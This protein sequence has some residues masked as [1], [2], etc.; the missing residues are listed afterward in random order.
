MKKYFNK[1]R[2]LLT[3]EEKKVRK[4]HL[5]LGLLSG[6][7]MG[8]SFPP[9]PLPYLAFFGLIPYLYVLEERDGL[10]EINRF[11]YFTFFFFNLITLYWVGSWTKDADS[12][13]LIAG[14]TLMFFNPLL[15]LIPSTLYYFA[16][17]RFGK[18][19]ALFALPVFWGFYEYIYSVTDFRFPW[20]MLGNSLTTFRVFIQIADIIGAYGISLLIVY[21]NIMIY[22]SW[23]EYLSRKNIHFGFAAG[24]L[25]FIIVPLVY[26]FIKSSADYGSENSVRF[27]LIQPNINPW[28][29]WEAG[30]LDDQLDLYLDL[31]KQAVDENAKV[32]A[33]PESALPVYLLNGRYSSQVKRI[34]EFLDSNNVYLVT[35]M[36][37][38]TFYF[39]STKAPDDAKRSR[40]GTLYTS[41]NSILYFAPNSRKVEKYGKI[42]LVPFGEKVPLVESIPV[43]GDL[44]KWNVGISSWNTGRGVKVF[45]MG[46]NGTV[47][48]GVICIESIYPAF[49]AEFVQSG[50]GVIAVVTNDSWYGNSSGPYQHKDIAVMRAIEN[51]R[52]VV[53]AANGGISCLIDPSGKIIKHT[54]M[55]TRD[56]LTVDVSINYDETFFS[57]YP[58]LIPYIS[59]AGTMLL[60][61]IT[62]F[63]KFKSRFISK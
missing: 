35:G 3:P 11:T 47:I 30:S 42:M 17:K 32:I 26:G 53:R 12:Y 31:S 55:F 5:L 56:Y 29:K 34:H 28:K 41:Y 19:V 20:L 4:K 15:F 13:L 61:L 43:L 45:E 60:L 38:A 25:L 2:S 44:F 58:R 14:T 16:K 7:L 27:G 40:S 37:D 8:L 1:Y 52:S 18:T 48:G 63:D 46:D 22:K 36:P 62:V 33:W 54:E 59:I 50:A 51:R 10:A 6:I 39:D 23:Q 21:L 57:A 49:C 24:V 9:I